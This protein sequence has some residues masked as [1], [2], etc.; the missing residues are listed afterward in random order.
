MAKVLI[1]GGG[2][3]GLMSPGVMFSTMKCAA[4]GSGT[5][6]AWA[7]GASTGAIGSFAEGVESAMLG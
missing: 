5:L 4:M 3:A 2:A 7:A 6:T 1:V